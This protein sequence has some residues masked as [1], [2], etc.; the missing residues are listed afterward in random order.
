[1]CYNT[2]VLNTTNNMTLTKRT[3]TRLIIA[4]GVALICGAKFIGKVLQGDDRQVV[5]QAGRKKGNPDAD[6]KIIEYMDFQCGACAK[7][8][9]IINSYLKDNPDKISMEMNH[10]PLRF[11][12]HG[13]LSSRYA[14]CAS[15]QGKFWP[16]HDLL[17]KRQRQWSK[18]LNPVPVFESFAKESGIYMDEFKMCLEDETVDARIVE[19]KAEGK[20]R[21]VKATPTYF[22]NGEMVVGV[23]SLIKELFEYFGKKHESE[24]DQPEEYHGNH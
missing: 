2:V 21:G 23:K 15:R 20:A 13:F 3:L 8:A 6:L 4:G 18:L 7:G 24:Q 17:I 10:F 14:E 19:I 12:K 22:I 16:Y 11:H 9:I 5:V 1:M